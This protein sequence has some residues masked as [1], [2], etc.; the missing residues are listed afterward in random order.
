MEYF[1][2]ADS[3]ESVMLHFSQYRIAD[4][5]LLQ[6]NRYTPM[7]EEVLRSPCSSISIIFLYS[8]RMKL[9]EKF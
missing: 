5:M 7:F 9:A 3:S 1:C 2:E 4:K 6:E 8:S